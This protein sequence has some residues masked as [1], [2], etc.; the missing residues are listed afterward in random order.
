MDNGIDF[1]LNYAGV[2]TEILKSPKMRAVI[3]RATAQVASTASR[4]SGSAY[5]GVVKTGA[6]RVYG[7]VSPKGLKAG[8]SNQKYNILE[9]ALRSRS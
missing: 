8:L 3:E 9:K 4:M 5:K 6:R 1:K 7:T 2:G